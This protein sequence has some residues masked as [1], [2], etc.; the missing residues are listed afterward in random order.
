MEE[1]EDAV[2][3]PHIENIS[4]FPSNDGKKVRQS[5]NSR[6]SFGDNASL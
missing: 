1:D 4:G 5:G 6:P 3:T 2:S